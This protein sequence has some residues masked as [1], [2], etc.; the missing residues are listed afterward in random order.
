MSR[1]V[2]RHVSKPSLTKSRR[3]PPGHLPCVTAQRFAGKIALVTG[4]GRGLGRS[5][6]FRLAAEGAA[7]AVVDMN[8]KSA[9]QTSKVITDSGA[10]AISCEADIGER[11]DVRR[12]VRWCLE[13]LGG[14]DVLVNNAGVGRAAP[15]LEVTDDAWQE[16]LRVNLLGSFMMAQ[17]AARHM[18]VSGGG[19]IVNIAS[20]CAHW[21]NGNQVA[22]SASK[23]AVVALT[24]SIAM[25]LG[26]RGI[27]CN[28]LSP[29]PIDSELTN[30]LLN[31]SERRERERRNPLQ[32]FGQPDEIAA[33]V[34][35]LASADASY[36]N[37]AVLNIDG[38][39]LIAGIPASRA[40]D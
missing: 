36:V 3:P 37:G 21:A 38:G 19:R 31:S 33:A 17:E 14:L 23:A 8:E 39:L 29:G 40:R 18:V 11:E 26:D 10:R 24:R 16:I 32:R 27:Y 22:Y 35:F 1:A 15:F 28:A 25:E 20:I 13:R 5:I 7:V 9:L 34:A 6:A 4:A 12:T 30:S 2:G